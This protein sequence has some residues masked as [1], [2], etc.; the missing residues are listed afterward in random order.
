LQ[1]EVRGLTDVRRFRSRDLARVIM[2]T[3]TG[4]QQKARRQ[5]Y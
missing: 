5:R 2:A 4:G 1:G 3:A